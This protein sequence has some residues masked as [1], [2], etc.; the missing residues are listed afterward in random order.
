MDSLT[1]R[2]GFVVLFLFALTIAGL[3]AKCSISPKPFNLSFR[4]GNCT[5]GIGDNS[6]LPEVC[7]AQSTLVNNALIQGVRGRLRR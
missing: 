6:L 7:Q 3:G 1:L 2:F 5:A 4:L